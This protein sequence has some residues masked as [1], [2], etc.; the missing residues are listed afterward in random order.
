MP[1]LETFPD[2]LETIEDLEEA[3][4]RPS[5]GLVEDLKRLDGDILILGVGGK[6]GPTLARMARRALD[7]AGSDARVIGVARFSDPAARDSL[8]AHGIETI[9][10]D[11]LD[12]GNLAALPDAPNIVYMAGR[13]FG[14]TGQESLTWAMNVYLPGVVAERFPESRIAAFSTGNVYPFYPVDSPGPTEQDA[15]GP[16]G[17]YA[18]S[19]LGRERMFQHFSL[20]HNTPVCIIRLNYAIDLRYGVLLDIATKVHEGRTIDLSMG[21][22]NVIW[23]GDAN[24]WSLRALALC[25]SPAAILN[26]TGPGVMAVRDVARRFGEILGREPE[27]T[28]IESPTAL[29]NNAAKANELFGPPRVD[30]EQMIRWTAAWVQQ[31]GATLS[32][33]THFEVRDGKF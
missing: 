11:L 7:E 19:C 28:G 3:L 27:L 24:D 17:E 32:K 29:L 2:T 18:Q 33:P 1:D 20:A 22:A 31:G 13:K 16:I 30:L 15:T 25:A 4:S 12:R 8:E 21:H 23:Q 9:T 10:A 14:S 5:T 6:M 26:L